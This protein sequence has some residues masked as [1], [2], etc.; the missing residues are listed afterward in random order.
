MS[1]YLLAFWENVAKQKDNARAAV[2]EKH[3]R[4]KQYSI[5][6]DLL[7]EILNEAQYDTDQAIKQTLLLLSYHLQN[8]TQGF[9]HD[10][11]GIEEQEE[12]TIELSADNGII[13]DDENSPPLHQFPSSSQ[14][15]SLSS[16][17]LSQTHG[18]HF[19]STA[20]LQ[21]SPQF[22]RRRQGEFLHFDSTSPSQYPSSNS[23][24]R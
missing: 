4:H 8:Y 20:Q 3:K 1:D 23:G 5:R 13:N 24:S 18:H 22:P 10:A 12:D 19:D 9:R 15:H 21:I 11:R 17:Q 2:I 7:V 6:E 14:S 16:A